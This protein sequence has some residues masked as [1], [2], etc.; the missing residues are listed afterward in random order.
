ME[1]WQGHP[2]DTTHTHMRQFTLWMVLEYFI[3]TQT[4]KCCKAKHH[5]LFLRT[6][7]C[8]LRTIRGFGNRPSWTEVETEGVRHHDMG[9]R[10]LEKRAHSLVCRLVNGNAGNGRDF[11]NV[12]EAIKGYSRLWGGVMVQP[13]LDWEG[14]FI[15]YLWA[16]HDLFLTFLLFVTFNSKSPSLG[17]QAD[18]KLDG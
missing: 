15:C 13:L 6:D 9:P 4:L 8:S 18:F 3:I 7:L 14:C 5:F 17:S 2:V 10:G 1:R 12:Q 16:N 11:L